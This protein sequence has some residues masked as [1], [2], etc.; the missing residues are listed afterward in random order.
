MASPLTRA[1]TLGNGAGTGFTAG[2]AGV[3][4]CAPGAAVDWPAGAAGWP[5]CAAGWVAGAAAWP[6]GGI[7]PCWAGDEVAGVGFADWAGAFWQP[8]LSSRMAAIDR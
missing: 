1:S 7:A 4:P 3:A 5:V 8:A 2:W 6:D